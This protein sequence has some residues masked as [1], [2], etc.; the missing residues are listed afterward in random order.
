MSP[1]PR[2]VSDED[3]FMAAVRVMTHVGPAELTLTAIAEEAG[4]TAGA[5]VQRF[6]SKRDLLVTMSRLMAESTPDR[7][8]A[9]RRDHGSA[10]ETL[11][12]YAACLADLAPSPEGLARNLAYLQLDLTDPD[13]HAPLLAQSRTTRA[14]LKTLLAE[15]IEVGD[16]KADTD[17]KRL[18]RVVETTFSG[19]LM[20]WAVYREG[21]AS[22]WLQRDLELALEPFL[23]RRGARRPRRRMRAFT[24]S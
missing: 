7:L 22:A 9:M 19:S 3:V 5:L 13:L 1:R 2:K 6:G 14:A 21:P 16:L 11:R 20:T 10:L 18:A 4:V 12:A 15:A 8:S 17:P 24:K 23:T